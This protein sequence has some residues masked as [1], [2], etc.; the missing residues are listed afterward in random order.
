[1]FMNLVCWI[2]L[3]LIGAAALTRVMTS[4]MFGVSVRDAVSFSSAA[5]ILAVVA[6]LA[7]FVPGRRATRID[8]LAALRDE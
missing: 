7:S 6:L 5:A 8:P 4:L 2:A 3:G 1:M